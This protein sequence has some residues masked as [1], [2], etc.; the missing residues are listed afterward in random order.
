[1]YYNPKHLQDKWVH[2]I[3]TGN[4]LS[5]FM[6]SS[7]MDMCTGYVS[8]NRLEPMYDELYD[9]ESIYERRS[10]LKVGIASVSC[11]YKLLLLNS[12]IINFH[13]RHKFS[14]DSSIALLF[15]MALFSFVVQI[16]AGGILN[17]ILINYRKSSHC[18][19]GKNST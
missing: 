18:E 10:Q 16:T 4:R 9:M 11:L 2:S 15:W 8:I 19:L 14:R 13:Y 12:S 6:V 17:L 5:T 7:P 1:M 3:N